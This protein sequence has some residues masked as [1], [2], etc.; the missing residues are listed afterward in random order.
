MKR[1]AEDKIINAYSVR[2][3]VLKEL[4][5]YIVPLGLEEFQQLEQ[6]IIKDG[7]REALIVWDTKDKQ[8]LIDGHNRYEICQKHGISFKT[9]SMVFNDLN[10]VKLWMVENQMGRRNLSAD[11]MS[12]YRGLKY[13]SL[14]KRKG[15]YQNVKSKGQTD[16]S[17]SEFI[18]D[19]FNVSES[20]VK[21]DAKFA[22]G[23]NII[24]RTN[25][26]LKMKILTGEVK[27]KKADVQILSSA[28]NA[29]DI[30]I[31]NE[32]DLFNKA[33]IIRD[34]MLAEV[35]S[36]VEKIHAEKISESRKVLN[37]VEPVF[38]DREDRL[39]KIKGMVISAINRAIDRRDIGAIKEL[40]DL[41]DKLGNEILE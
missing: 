6:N 18:A 7:C 40:K 31:K 29:E 36:N 35:E 3:A 20:T 30:S 21:R 37:A 34:E 14:K 39:R 33:K 32:A 9:K 8:I 15:G 22:E 24:G 13:L 1:G 12:Y 28:S 10:E 4:K 38:L 17:T 41:I 11:Q 2:I 19:Q 25:P 16:T 23:L 26:K 27:V 5:D